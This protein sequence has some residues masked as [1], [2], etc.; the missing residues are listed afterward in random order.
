MRITIE[1]KNINNFLLDG[2]IK[3]NY[4]KPKINKIIKDQIRKRYI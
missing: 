4:Q 1:I 2:K 3:N